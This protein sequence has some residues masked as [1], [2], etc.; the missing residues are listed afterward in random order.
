MRYSDFANT[1]YQPSVELGTDTLAVLSN[2][3][4]MPADQ[5]KTLATQLQADQDRK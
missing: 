2:V 3:L 1:P 5:A 4:N